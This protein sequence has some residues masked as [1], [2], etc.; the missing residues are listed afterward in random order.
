M[1]IN[2]LQGALLNPENSDKPDS[3]EDDE[4]NDR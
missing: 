3:Q 2:W 1:P 4:E